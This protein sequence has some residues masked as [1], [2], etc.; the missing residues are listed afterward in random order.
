MP[1]L[2]SEIDVK[3]ERSDLARRAVLPRQTGPDG[4]IIPP[5][6]SAGLH[7]SGLLK[8]CADISKL[9]SRLEDIRDEEM[10]L[11]WVLGHAIEEF[12]ASL[13]PDMVWQPGEITRPVIMNAD[14]M[15][16][17]G[18]EF[19][20]EEFKCRRAKKLT[21]RDLLNKWLWMSQ[22]LGY[23]LGYQ[24]R[25]VQWH[26]FSLFEWPDPVYTRYLIKFSQAE[27]DG[28][29]RMIESNREAA[30]RKGYSE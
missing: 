18:G 13:Y 14:G 1:T 12:L 25:L 11:R 4:Y 10:P 16:F 30:I 9:T 29:E 15:T 2:I 24:C 28:M 3:L 21:Q 23:C 20:I 5:A 22:G 26:V 8:Y 17:T 19:R 7:L 27:I 6:R